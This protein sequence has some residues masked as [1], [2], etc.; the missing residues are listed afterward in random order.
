MNEEDWSLS[1][2]KVAAGQYHSA[3]IGYSEIEHA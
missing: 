2:M 3:F 1:H